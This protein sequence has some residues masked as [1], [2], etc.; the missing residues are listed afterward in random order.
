MQLIQ[1][2]GLTGGDLPV[3]LIRY[4]VSGFVGDLLKGGVIQAV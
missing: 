3:A 1:E 2:Q 4:A